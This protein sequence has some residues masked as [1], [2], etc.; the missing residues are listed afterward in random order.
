VKQTPGKW[1]LARDGDALP[2]LDSI[3]LAVLAPERATFWDSVGEIFRP[4][5][6]AWA[7]L[8]FIWL[9]L[10]AAHFAISPGAPSGSLMP[11][12]GPVLD[13]LTTMSPDETLSFLDRHS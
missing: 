11:R 1:L 13:S 4:N 6:P 10:A 9:V 5:L 12:H 2:R 3:R 8:T 7:S